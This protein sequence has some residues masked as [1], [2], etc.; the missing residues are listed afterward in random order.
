[1]HAYSFTSRPGRSFGA[2]LPALSAVLCLV[3][4]IASLPAVGR[5]T[6]AAPSTTSYAAFARFAGVGAEGRDMIWR[7]PV[8]GDWGSELT[9]RLAHV[10]V[11]GAARRG[12]QPVEGILFVAAD[13]E[14]PERALASEV[15]GTMDLRTGRVV[16]SG[17]VSVGSQEGERLTF[18]ANLVD[19]DLSGDVQIGARI[20]AR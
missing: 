1:M 7:G 4:M 15:A 3:S 6:T 17:T 16:V 13:P 9:V 5:A 11:D 8:A 18:V 12:P 19:G 10:A 14:R 2:S 20:A